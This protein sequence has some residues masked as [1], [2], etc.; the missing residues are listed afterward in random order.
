M[1]PQFSN[2]NSFR[3]SQS[4]GLPSTLALAPAGGALV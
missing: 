3:Q 2:T 4:M 1:A